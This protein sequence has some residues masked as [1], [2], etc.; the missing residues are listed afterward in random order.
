MKTL[1]SFVLL[2]A[3]VFLAP[4]AAAQASNDPEILAKGEYI[5]IAS[6][7]TACHSE[8]HG[9]GKPFAGGKAISSPVGTIFATNITPSKTFGIGD[10]TEEQF[11]NALRK[12]VAA[13]GSHLYPAMPYTAYAKLT[14]EDIHALYSYFMNGVEPVDHQVPETELPFPMNLRFSMAFWNALFLDEAVHEDDPAQS[15]S[16]NR[17]RYLVE[18]PTHCATCHTPRGFLMQEQGS[19]FLGGAQVGP[20]YAPNITPDPVSGIGSWTKEELVQYL[21]TGS[22]AGKAQAGGSMAEAIS[23]SFQHLTDSD[24]N[25]IADYLATVPAVSN[26]SENRFNQG[27]AG[28]KLAAFRGKDFHSETTEPG[29]RIYSGSCASCHGYNAQG[30]EDGY[31]P[32][33]FN[34]SASGEENASNLIAAII[35]GVDRHTEEGGH[36]FMP[37]F[38]DQP[39]ALNNLDDEQIAQLSN[40]IIDMHGL[41]GTQV[42]PEEVAVIRAG[43]AQSPLIQFARVGMAAGAAVVAVL[44]VVLLW[45]RKRR[46]LAKR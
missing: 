4:F 45:R 30:T 27:E 7:C 32:S 16:W 11:A 3:A 36:V 13:D 2:G 33:L 39:N 34:N 24:L 20:W 38:G 41:K 44:L 35:Y 31:Y 6:D 46:Q 29:A 25:A 19:K 14:D 17:G 15:E 26:A 9:G 37:P 28:N 10:Y 22:V 40:Y 21:K 43:G 42:T 12:G 8:E 18:G 1:T 5:A 23:F